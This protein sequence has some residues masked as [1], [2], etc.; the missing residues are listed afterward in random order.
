[1]CTTLNFG[2]R[3]LKA[4]NYNWAK[5]LAGKGTSS[6]TFLTPG[7]STC[8][9]IAVDIYGN[10]YI[11]G[12]YYDTVDFDPGPSI[13]YH[14]A[15]HNY[16]MFFAKYDQNGNFVWI[17]NLIGPIV[18]DI[19][20]DNA[21]DIVITGYCSDTSDFD[22]GPATAFLNVDHPGKQIFFIAKYNSSGNYIW[23]TGSGESI[24]VTDQDI[25][26]ND[27]NEIFITSQFYD[28]LV[29]PGT[30]PVVLTSFYNLGIFFAKY[31]ANGNMQW[32]KGIPSVGYLGG[33][34]AIETSD[35]GNIFITGFFGN[36][37]DFDPGPG[38]YYINA[39]TTA[40]RFLARY[41]AQGDFVWAKKINVND[42]G[43]FTT[44]RNIK[45]AIDNSEN[46]ILTGDF[47]GT[48]DFDPGT[49]T[50][51]LT[52]T[53]PSTFIGKYDGN[54]NFV[55]V[56]GITGGFCAVTGIKLDCEMSI[57]I[58]GFF[59]S[60]DFNPGP[61]TNYLAS[62]APS[63]FMNFLAKYDM[64]G[65]YSWASKIGNN[66]YAS[67]VTQAVLD[68]SQGNQFL[69]G[70]FKQTGDFDPGPDSHTLTSSG[71]GQNTFFAKYSS[72]SIISFPSDTILCGGQLLT[73][74]VTVAGANYLWHDSS[75][76]SILQVQQSGTYWV[77][78][79]PN[80]C[81]RDTVNV[82]IND[83][84]VDLGNDTT[85]CNKD[86]L[87]L[88]THN[89]SASSLWQDNSTSSQYLV[90][91]AGTYWIV[92]TAGQCQSSDTIV[93][94]YSDCISGLQMPNTFTPNNDGSNDYFSPMEYSYIP[95][96][97]LVIYNRW[98][99][100]VYET[101]N[102]QRGW[103]GQTGSLDCPDGTYFWTVDYSTRTER[104][105]QKSGFVTLIR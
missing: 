43:G 71:A 99:Q 52:A 76:A 77:E 61:A 83:T 55:W 94:D 23:S 39:T 47:S 86:E 95:S 8:S 12:M 44:W 38:I 7:E 48:V 74:D 28:T 100:K 69:A 105:N 32:A 98:G 6:I 103:N 54:G 93:I 45:P 34:S 90:R 53:N 9:A 63:A 64:N 17:K 75:T 50:N 92:V 72:T 70:G 26:I 60:A 84:E 33:S 46:I 78:V 2:A 27:D 24:G 14:Y 66:G 35:N 29:I 20:I 40:D 56:K 16:A 49:G 80:N 58:A 13:F 22:P 4:Q 62:N 15:N 30:N 82:T 81:I 101:N 25:S 79:S 91:E 3:N 10:T 11:T 51:N 87:L 104:E 67:N 59:S 42:H 68:V 18:K 19:C 65:N 21:G 36:Q 1:V 85:M 37:V 31:D 41:N 5:S 97:H 88:N 73:L 96:A 57:F 102:L 89:E